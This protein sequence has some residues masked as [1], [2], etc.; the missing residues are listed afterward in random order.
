M[1][2]CTGTASGTCGLG[3]WTVGTSVDG[4]TFTGN[5]VDVVDGADFAGFVDNT[6]ETGGPGF[7]GTGL[8]GDTGD[9][10]ISWDFNNDF[11]D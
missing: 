1:S 7:R 10:Y 8:G 3:N 11:G 6:Y 5:G 9:V 2:R 4:S